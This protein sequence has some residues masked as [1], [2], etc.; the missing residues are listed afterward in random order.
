MG[1]FAVNTK[2]VSLPIFCRMASCRAAPAA[3]TLANTA[4]I[5]KW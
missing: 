3:F 1:G 5:I 2:L 4:R